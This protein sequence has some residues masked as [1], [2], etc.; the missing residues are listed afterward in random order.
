MRKISSFSLALFLIACSPTLVS[1][2]SIVPNKTNFRFNNSVKNISFKVSLSDDIASLKGS[3][4]IKAKLKL[5]TSLLT[6]N[7]TSNTITIPYTDGVIGESPEI[8]INL[9][10]STISKST[11]SPF[12]I[13][14]AAAQKKKLKLENF[15]DEF[16]LDAS[17]IKVSGRVTIPTNSAES[18][19]AR[20][21][22]LLKARKIKPLNTENPDGVLVQLVPI[23]S[24]TGE[25]SGAPVAEAVTNSQG[26]YNLEMPANT[27][28]GTDY[29]LVVEG[30][31]GESM[32]APLFSD[33]VNITPASETLFQ[34]TQEAVQNPVNIG[35]AANS[36]ISFENFTDREALGL[37]NQ[38][39]ELA[40]IYE[41]TL[42]ES[43]ESLRENYA[44]FLNNMLGA[45]ADD[46]ST[47]E[48]TDIG[49][50]AR[51][52]AGDYFVSFFNTSISS[53]QRLR[54]SIELAAAR[55]SRPDEVGALAVTPFPSFTS[56]ASSQ[57]PFRFSNPGE[58]QTLES[59]TR[60]IKPRNETGCYEVEAFSEAAHVVRGTQDGNFYMTVDANRMISFAEP[61]S[62]ESFTTPEGQQGSQRYLPQVMTMIPVGEGMFL[63]NMTSE[64]NTI[65]E[66][67][68]QSSDYDTGFGSIIKK[69]T[70]SVSDLT[71]AY[72]IVGLGYKVATNDFGST[73]FIGDLNL[74]S[75]QV[76]FAINMK[77]IKLDSSACGS[78]TFTLTR[79]NEQTTGSAN[80]SIERGR[81]NIEIASEAGSDA[82][83]TGFARPDGKILS[84]IYA[85]D[86]GA[87]G[88]RQDHEGRSRNII[89]SAERQILIGVKKPS[90]ILNLSGKRYRILSMNYA[91]NALGGRTVKSGEIGT[92][93][94]DQTTL[95]ISNL[96][97]T[98]Y[99]KATANSNVLVTN[100]SNSTAGIAY[101]LDN[102]G[103][104][105]FSLGSETLSGYVAEDSSLIVLSS[106]ES[107]SLGVYY[108]ILDTSF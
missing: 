97:K 82:L 39:E 41:A 106:D 69:S 100:D 58:G 8:I 62:E 59:P 98:V 30:S 104:I 79:E 15:S 87:R 36:E 88:S 71:G 107:S 7:L 85:S 94:F 90:T 78:D 48:S 5:D 54:T 67:N 23:N 70:P 26:T 64:S 68:L 95:T 46:D 81:I 86:M 18:F 53:E 72:G 4:E 22:K 91:F 17:L 1:A 24:A 105:E 92:L 76:N 42:S 51:S 108:A 77:A 52:I 11:A 16:N 2:I 35:L 73:A 3:G 96:N 31:E 34:L 20:T 43:V 33:S 9:K 99:S 55:M 61:A 47:G 40:P 12:S 75:S 13:K 57:V 50:A 32:H 14:F 37:N 27:E 84:L 49:E 45:S 74:N 83:F 25:A 44:G 19:K 89:E 60:I 66:G 101:T 93:S 6:S 56:E 80:L 28:F 10:N 21:A 65:L 63:S 38:L 102:Q 29:A 103:K